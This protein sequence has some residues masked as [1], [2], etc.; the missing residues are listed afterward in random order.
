M[1]IY[2]VIAVVV[3]ALDQLTKWLVVKNMA[4][5]ES[6]PIIDGFF[7]LTSYR[8]RGAAW[9]ILEG[10]M[11]FFYVIT[12]IVV[13]GIIYFMQKYGKG[14]RLLATSFA[15]ILGGAIGNFIDR[16][17]RKE[18]VDFFDFNIFG[19]HYPIFNIADSALVIGI[20]MLLIVS[21]IEDRRKGKAAK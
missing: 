2:Y 5:Y 14:S 12:A 4:L 1:Y 13:V 16:I 3:I 17:V 8:N 10:K 7:H 6:I 18:V 15:M 9:G 19:Y 21:F 20:I 11:F